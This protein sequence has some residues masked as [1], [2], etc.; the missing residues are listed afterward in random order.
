MFDLLDT[1]QKNIELTAKD[2]LIPLENKDNQTLKTSNIK[3][4]IIKMGRSKNILHLPQ[5]K[6][7]QQE[8]GIN[9]KIQ[10]KNMSKY[11][12]IVR[13]N[14]KREYIDFSHDSE[15]NQAQITLASLAE[16]V[17]PINSLEQQIS[18]VLQKNNIDT[19]E[20]IIVKFNLTQ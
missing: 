12:P 13:N 9:Y 3:S 14:R 16:R 1:S 7:E 15:S 5:Y 17:Q 19:Q 4:Q 10:T 6:R 2:L 18:S 20:A 11:I 8:R